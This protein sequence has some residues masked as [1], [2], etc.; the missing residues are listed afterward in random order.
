MRE[1]NFKE[2]N[3]INESFNNALNNNEELIP[4]TLS[5]LPTEV[6]TPFKAD[7]DEEE[8]SEPVAKILSARLTKDIKK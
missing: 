5:T 8:K 7:E 1:K 2:N 6:I 4:E 3:S